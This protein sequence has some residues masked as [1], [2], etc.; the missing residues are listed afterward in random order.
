M[1][2]GTLDL[3][4]DKTADLRPLS[5]FGG[6][7]HPAEGEGLDGVKRNHRNAIKS[8]LTKSIKKPGKPESFVK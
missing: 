1:A 8:N 2:R 5:S 7:H 4:N 6:L 3:I